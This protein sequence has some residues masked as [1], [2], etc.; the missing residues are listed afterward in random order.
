MNE[1]RLVR[2]LIPAV[3]FYI[4][5]IIF[6]ANVQINTSTLLIGAAAILIVGIVVSCI[7]LFRPFQFMI[8]ILL[9]M[10]LG[11]LNSSIV[12]T[13]PGEWEAVDCEKHIVE[14]TVQDIRK[15]TETYDQYILDHIIIDGQAYRG[16]VIASAFYDGSQTTQA[17]T[18]GTRVKI[19][20]EIERPNGA[21]N[22][23]LFDYR[24][25]LLRQGVYAQIGASAQSYYVVA[26]E[27]IGI[28]ASLIEKG[29]AKVTQ[30][31]QQ[32]IGGD[33]AMVVI[34]MIIGDKTEI[35]EN[36]EK[37]FKINGVAH[38]LAIS[39]LHVG[40]LVALLMAVLKVLHTRK[41]STFIIITLVLIGYCLLTGARPSTIRATIMAVILLG[42]YS[43]GRRA[44]SVNALAVAALVILLIKP[45]DLF[46]VGFQLSFAA[47]LAIIL[48][49]RRIARRLAFLLPIVAQSIAVVIAAQIGTIPVMAYHFNT[50]SVMAFFANVPFVFLAGMIVML[51]FVLLIVAPVP[52]INAGVGIVIKALVALLTK[53]SEGLSQLPW[54]MRSVC[55]PSMMMLIGIGILAWLLSRECP[56]KVV[57][58]RYHLSVVVAVLVCVWLYGAPKLDHRAQMTVL[59]V[60]QGDAIHIQTPDDKNILIDT[61]GVD[62]WYTGNFEPGADVVVPYFLKNGSKTIDLLILTH[63]HAD[64]IGGVPAVIESLNVKTVIVAEANWYQ[65]KLVGYDGDILEVQA[66]DVLNNRT[67]KLTVLNPSWAT[68]GE[69]DNNDSIVI[70]LEMN[71]VNILLTGDSETP[72]CDQIAPQID[73]A[74]IIKVPHHGGNSSM[75]VAYFNHVN[76]QVAIASCGENNV[77]GHPHA[78]I[79][80]AYT[81]KGTAFYQTD[82]QGAV[83]ITISPSKT[84]RVETMIES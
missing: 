68:L 38:I 52:F 31:I 47:V 19:E 24:Q 48:F 76:A 66:G 80:D 56:K 70:M 1:T 69:G 9:F 49:S 10:A 43:L 51:S 4:V 37:S 34:G 25:Y 26:Q 29:N 82:E 20:T 67:T 46:D 53:C 78:E 83:T 18:M 16:K 30:I 33:E 22:P 28:I 15:Q 12:S 63:A 21:R 74:N 23:H 35:P 84:F 5:G 11:M 50:F 39:G 41:G 8:F 14:G 42:G 40:F 58:W 2:P 54:A 62:S 73:Q 72:V 79:V 55:S 17:Y 81:R 61:G 57:K 6:G 45:L 71:G 65:E 75:S 64:H 36:I 44:D 59:D 3:F 7:P 77:Y 60:G 27:K 32:W 13:V